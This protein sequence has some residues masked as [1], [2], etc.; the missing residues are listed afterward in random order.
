MDTSGAKSELGLLANHL[1]IVLLSSNG[2]E[3][4]GRLDTD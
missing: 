4:R 1:R 3:L 2:V